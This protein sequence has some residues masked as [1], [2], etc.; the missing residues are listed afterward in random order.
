ML[1]LRQGRP[2]G[3]PRRRCRAARR[4]RPGDLPRLYPALRERTRR[5]GP[6]VRRSVVPAAARPGVDPRRGRGDRPDG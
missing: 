3:A 1:V 5:P 4:R 2:P 6:A